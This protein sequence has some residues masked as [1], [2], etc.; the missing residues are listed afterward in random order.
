M[1]YDPT[2]NPNFITGDAAKPSSKP[3]TAEEL[4]RDGYTIERE[5]KREKD[6]RRGQK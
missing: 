2:K 5:R 6:P 1:S 4:E 3:R